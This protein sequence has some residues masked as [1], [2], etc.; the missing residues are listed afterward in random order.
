MSDLF[1]H[2]PGTSPIHRLPAG[3]KLLALFVASIVMMLLRG[4]LTSLA[5]LA[6]AVVV[7]VLAGVRWPRL[8]WSLRGLAVILVLIAAYQ[9]WKN[10]WM[11]A[12][13]V[14]GDLLTVVLLASVVTMTT[15]I[16]RMLDAVSAGMRPL[17]PLGVRSGRVALTITLTL[18]MI[19]VALGL[20]AQSRDAARA[21]GL[22]RSIRARMV[23]TVIRMVA[24][25]RTTG[26]AL[27][28]RGV[29]ELDR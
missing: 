26:D 14:V 7:A 11:R 15:P 4:H 8:L 20:P 21:R 17:Q 24:H 10:D 16:D 3:V 5:G 23:P 27:W 2:Q 18:Q 13:E 28:A 6:V 19:P 25:A 29:D 12:V 1:R 9:L 22:E